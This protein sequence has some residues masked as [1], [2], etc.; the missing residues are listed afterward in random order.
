VG[1]WHEHLRQSR[2]G[3]GLGR[4]PDYGDAEID[5]KGIGG[6][7]G[8]SCLAHKAVEQRVTV[9]ARLAGLLRERKLR[10]AG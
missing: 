10:Y 6:G 7:F 3:S 5:A 2:D 4:F 1:R 9:L 8:A